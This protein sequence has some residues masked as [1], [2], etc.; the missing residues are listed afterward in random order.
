[1]IRIKGL[2]NLTASYE[3]FDRSEMLCSLER[4]ECFQ[5][6][7]DGMMDGGGCDEAGRQLSDS[8]LFLAQPW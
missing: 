3:K 7:D 4:F 5:A 2:E 6:D 8:R 1:M